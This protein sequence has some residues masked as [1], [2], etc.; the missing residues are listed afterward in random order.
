MSLSRT[1]SGIE[2]AEQQPAVVDVD[3][4]RPARQTRGQQ[5]VEAFMPSMPMFEGTV[6]RQRTAA[7]AECLPRWSPAL[8]DHHRRPSARPFVTGGAVLPRRP[9]CGDRRPSIHTA[10]RWRLAAHLGVAMPAAALH[11]SACRALLLRSA[12]LAFVVLCWRTG[13]VDVASCRSRSPSYSTTSMF[14]APRRVV[15]R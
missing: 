13:A 9:G 10:A 4:R 12:E 5:A 2:A 6:L 3:G 11:R 14:P 1:P 15:A 7:C 8:G